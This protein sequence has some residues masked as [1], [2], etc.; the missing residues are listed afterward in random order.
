MWG[1]PSSLISSLLVP[2]EH[3]KEAREPLQGDGLFYRCGAILCVN[4]RWLI[5]SHASE[6][7]GRQTGEGAVRKCNVT[8]SFTGSW[9]EY[10][11]GPPPLCSVAVL[12]GLKQHRLVPFSFWKP[13]MV[14]LKYPPVWLP[15]LELTLCV[16]LMREEEKKKKKTALALNVRVCAKLVT[17]RC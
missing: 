7:L 13:S 6:Q 16:F 17:T 12:S 4:S 10:S 8:C 2:Y 15:F 1:F 14:A 11:W 9:P 5:V 3:P